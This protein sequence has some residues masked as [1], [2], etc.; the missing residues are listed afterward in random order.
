MAQDPSVRKRVDAGRAIPTLTSQ[1]S[2]AVRDTIPST[3]CAQRTQQTRPGELANFED[4]LTAN[5]ASFHL[6]RIFVVECCA[7]ITKRT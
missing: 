7:G 3:V 1:G 4:Y 5:E 6:A 2:A